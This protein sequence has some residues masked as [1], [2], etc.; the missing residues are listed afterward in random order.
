MKYEQLSTKSISSVC[1]KL[2]VNMPNQ[3]E[4]K[5]RRNKAV[6]GQ[7]TLWGVILISKA[8][9]P[10]KDSRTPVLQCGVVEFASLN[11]LRTATALG[12]DAEMGS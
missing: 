2:N 10:P 1:R 4:T 11:E 12:V 7:S 8:L 5:E 6:V 3:K 9:R